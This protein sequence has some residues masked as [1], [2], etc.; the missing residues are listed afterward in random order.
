MMKPAA[1]TAAPEAITPLINA[2]REVGLR[3]KPVRRPSAETASVADP[4]LSDMAVSPYAREVVTRLSRRPRERRSR[5]RATRKKFCKFLSHGARGCTRSRVA[6]RSLSL[7]GP[8]PGSLLDN[9]LPVHPRVRRADV[10][11]G[12]GL[13]E[14]DRLRFALGQSAGI[15]VADLAFVERRRRVRKVADIGE[16]Q[17][18]A[19]LDP[20]TGRPI[21]IFRIVV[22]DF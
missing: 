6:G 4:S 7:A 22:G 20:N 5:R 13:F 2:R 17:R 19:R 8:D 9:D 14:G 11:V 10:E 16:G 3:A 1:G 21:G 18:R 15:P 12:A